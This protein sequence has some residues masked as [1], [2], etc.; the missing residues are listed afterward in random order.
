MPAG[1]SGFSISPDG[2]KLLYISSIPGPVKT[3]KDSDPALDKASAY[4]V[5]DLM[6]R[7]WDHWVTEVP[8]SFVADLGAGKITPENSRDL[9]GEGNLF[10][11][12]T[13]PFGG[14][15]Q[16]SWSPD[17]RF[18]AYSCRKKT[19]VQ[20]A[21]STD[22]EIYI[23]R[24]EDLETV[25][26]PMG[27]GYDTDPVWSPDGGRL[28]WLSMERDGYE[29]DKTR[30]MV[31]DVNFP[32]VS[33][34]LDLSTAVDLDAESP[35]WL[36][37]GSGVV[38]SAACRGL[39]GVYC[40]KDEAAPELQMLSA[41]D[42][43][44]TL[45]TPVQI[46]PDGTFISLCN[47]MLEPNEIVL[48]DAASGQ[49]RKLS[50]ENTALLAGLHACEVR[51]EDIPTVDGKLMQVWSIYPPDFDPS[52]EYPAILI[53]LGGPQ[54]HNGQ[55]WSYRWNY[56]LMASQGYIVIMPNRRGTT[57]FGQ[58]WKEQISG[59]YPGL[60]MQDYLSA[61]RYFKAKPY[62]GKMAACGASYGG[63]SVYY[64]AGMHGGVFDCFIA[65]AGIFDEKYMWFTTEEMWF[66][67]FDNGGLGAEAPVFGGIAQPGAPYS[68][69]PRALRHYASSP[70]SM[71]T[72]WNTPIL[73]IHGG[74]DFRIPYDQGMAAF[75]AARMMGVPAKL[76]V[77]P[78]ENHWI[79]QPQNALYWHR[80]YFD[81]LY[82][83]LK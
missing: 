40:L 57:S 77:F 2:S 81:W 10:E 46:N 32:S 42:W 18:I 38:F 25:C 24:V 51:Q 19:G 3:P 6:Y 75:N 8:R 43:Q 35:C 20:Y 23:C 28:A 39:G 83:W 66:P 21:F 9:L 64:L 14:I 29:A 62:V 72:A 63:Y 48:A 55:D 52:R 34:I 71:V 80:S 45:S 4:A 36:E 61:A 44:C 5:E 74:K 70:E 7:H 13:E 12:P 82:R 65:H 76:I 30:L 78:E 56:R 67:N 33:G 1:I 54:S 31:C 15:E 49:I 69:A 27:G 41:P 58:E 59:D 60:N 16:L 50:N 47:S 73:C 22:T 11:L 68:N 37:D 17:S 79:L 26:I 53:T